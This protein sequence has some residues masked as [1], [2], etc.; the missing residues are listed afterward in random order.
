M[1]L[2]NSR[3]RHHPSR[4]LFQFAVLYS[5]RFEIRFISSLG[6]FENKLLPFTRYVNYGRRARTHQRTLA[7]TYARARARTHVKHTARFPPIAFRNSVR[8]IRHGSRVGISPRENPVNCNN[9]PRVLAAG[10][11]VIIVR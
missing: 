1:C 5:S 9:R 2:K 8:P 3:R 11:I 10:L 6:R 7:R 4:E